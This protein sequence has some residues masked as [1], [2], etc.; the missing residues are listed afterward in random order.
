MPAVL[1]AILAHLRRVEVLRAAL[2]VLRNIVADDHSAM[3]LGGQGAYRIVFAVLQT[4]ATVEQL[5]LIRLGAAVLWRIHHARCPPTALLNS[6]LAFYT[7]DP[8]GFILGRNVGSGTTHGHG[9]LMLAPRDWS[10]SLGPVGTG[11]RGLL[12]MA[13]A[14]AAAEDV[15]ELD[16]DAGDSGGDNDD[17]EDDHDNEKRVVTCSSTTAEAPATDTNDR[18]TSPPVP[19]VQFKYAGHCEWIQA[20]PSAPEGLSASSL[21]AT[22][23]ELVVRSI[24]AEAERLMA[25]ALTRSLMEPSS[26]PGNF[27]ALNGPVVTMPMQGSADGLTAGGDQDRSSQTCDSTYPRVVYD[28]YPPDGVSQ[29]RGAVAS[30]LLFDADFESA[31]L[32]RAVQVGPREYNLVLNCDVNTRGHTQWFLFRVKAMEAGVGYRFHLINLMKPDSLF[33]SGMR[34]LAYSERSAAET[35]IGWMRT[36][37]EIAYFMNQYS[38]STTPKKT[39]KK[40]GVLN[41]TAQAGPTSATREAPLSSYYTLTFRVAFPHANDTVY[42]SQC[43]PYTY[44][45][46]Q[47][48]NFRLLQDCRSSVIRREVLCH[49]YGGN[50]CDVLTVTDFSAAPNEVRLLAGVS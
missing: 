31:N 38:Y 29:H 32:R 6:Q 47:K 39:V 37:D 35:G 17:G 30:S 11:P 12:A 8:N 42:I 14:A 2:I 45:M 25:P 48:L 10:H 22:H 36:A 23:A 43:Y 41:T 44:S 1:A 46:A 9:V 20:C 26:T 16:D 28:A 49:S 27:G 40:S 13:R 4:H 15:D 7:S 33:S 24:T 3:R 50:V 19:H 34:P 18:E 5:E 21:P